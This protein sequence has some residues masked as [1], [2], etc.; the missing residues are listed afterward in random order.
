MAGRWALGAGSPLG[1][2][3]GKAGARVAALSGVHT[4]RVFGRG[5]VRVAVILKY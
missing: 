4:Y 5:K 2:G 1:R 3:R